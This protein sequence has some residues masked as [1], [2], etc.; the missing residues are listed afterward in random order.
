MTNIK[1][2]RKETIDLIKSESP[3]LAS[4]SDMAIMEMYSRWS[5]IN[6]SAS[7]LIH[8]NRG[9]AAFIKWA[10]TSPCDDYEDAN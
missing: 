3:I 1:D 6:Y 5:Q 7:W 8:S 9:I 10:T 2:Y 4:K